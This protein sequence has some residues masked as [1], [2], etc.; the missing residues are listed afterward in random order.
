MCVYVCTW[1]YSLSFEDLT[2]IVMT[3]TFDLV[4]TFLL[5]PTWKTV[6]KS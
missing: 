1:W 5:V 2:R 6:Y 3:V 4:G